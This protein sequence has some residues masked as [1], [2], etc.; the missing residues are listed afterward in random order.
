MTR[1]WTRRG[2]AFDAPREPEFEAVQQ[3]D[4]VPTGAG[5]GAS[6]RTLSAAVRE[7]ALQWSLTGRQTEVLLLLARGDSNKEI[8]RALCCTP[9]TAEAHV[10]AILR[11]SR[12]RS[13]LKLVAALLAE[14]AGEPRT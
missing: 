2:L 3:G 7:V 1:D 14:V 12:L 11:K 6:D 9:G 5:G 8:A 10:T 13:R 4:G